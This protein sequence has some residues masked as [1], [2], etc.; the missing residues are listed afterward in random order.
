MVG[1]GKKMLNTPTRIVAIDIKDG[2]GQAQSVA[3]FMARL[4]RHSMQLASMTCSAFDGD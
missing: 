3:S 2:N 4:G 1:N